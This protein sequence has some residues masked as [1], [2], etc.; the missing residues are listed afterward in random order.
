MAVTTP[1]RSRAP[2]TGDFVRLKLRLMGNGFR[3]QTWRVVGFVFGLIFG[4][5]V[6]G[7]AVLGLAASGAAPDDV[8]YVVTAFVGG[9]VVLGWTLVPLLFFGV[10][11][12]LDPARFALLPIRRGR[13]ARGMLAAAFIGVPA[14]TTLFATSGLVIA[15]AI[16]FGLL[17][18]VVALFGVLSGLTLGVVASRAVTSAFAALLRSRRVRDL[19]AV[20]IALLATSVGPIQWLVVATFENGS[21]DAAVRVARVVGWTPFG[22]AYVLP[23]DVADGRWDLAAAHAAITLGSIG[24]LLWWW[25]H[26]LESAMLDNTSGGAARSSRSTRGGAVDALLPKAMRAMGRPGPFAAIMARESRFWW[27]DGRR[28]AALVS[29]LMASAVLPIALNLGGRASTT[30]GSVSGL[31]TVGFGFAVTMAGTMGGLLLGNQFGYDGSAFAAHLL[32][33]VRGRTELRARAAAIALVAVPVQV[34][35]V[36]AVSA[37]SGQLPIVPAGLGLLAGSFGAAVASAALLSVFAPYALPENANPFAM[38]SGAGSAK[39]MLAIVAMLGTLVLSTPVAVAAFL[40]GSSP[41]LS[42]GV[43][44]LGL[45][46]GVGAALLGTYIAGDALDRRGP[47]I[48]AAVTPKR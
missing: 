17:E 9:F 37:F 1:A 6:G 45:G 42:W 24:L 18:A 13:L 35:V 28:R 38:N 29:I 33:R 40:A 19:A 32:S 44:V 4:L 22:A 16:R 10:D 46:Y 14:M 25:S 20:I 30:P 31:S 8:G 3:G 11:E 27:R 26:T 48:L 23:F 47:E 15:A 21:L 36:V 7:L 2:G 43:L 5:F 34:F 41:A 12:T 39:G